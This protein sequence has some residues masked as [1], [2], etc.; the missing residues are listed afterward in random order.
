MSLAKPVIA[1]AYGASADYMLPDH[2]YPVDYQLVK[3]DQI[4]GAYGS[5][6]TWAE[7]GLGHAAQLMQHVYT[8]REEAASKG[9]AAAAFVAAR[10][11]LQRSGQQMMQRLEWLRKVASKTATLK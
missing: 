2:S 3:V 5:N 11:S 6:N 1:P 8:H 7:P 10:Y 4:W 9:E